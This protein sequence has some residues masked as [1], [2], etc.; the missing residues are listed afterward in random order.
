[1]DGD[2]FAVVNPATGEVL[3]QVPRM[4]ADETRRA[5]DAAADACPGW[6]SHGSYG[7]GRT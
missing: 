1:V 3:E 7:G 2:T 4:G 5:I 6:K